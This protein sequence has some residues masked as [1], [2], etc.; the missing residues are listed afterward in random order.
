MSELDYAY[1]KLACTEGFVL[2]SEVQ[3]VREIA[4]VG[5]PTIV[6]FICPLCEKLHT[7]K[8]EG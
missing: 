2:E 5:Q 4:L 6:L 7:S 1:L 3:I 8:R